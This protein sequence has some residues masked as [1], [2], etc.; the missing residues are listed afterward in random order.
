MSTQRRT[1]EVVQILRHLA[2]LPGSQALD[3]TAKRL[4]RMGP[5]E[6]GTPYEERTRSFS[7]DAVPDAVALPENPDEIVITV[8][9]SLPKP[10]AQKELVERLND[11][12]DQQELGQTWDVRTKFLPRPNGSPYELTVF[13]HPMGG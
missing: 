13:T 3:I 12:F 4:A 2:A 11:F 1:G 5:A 10:E 8:H 6:P 7:T 9:G